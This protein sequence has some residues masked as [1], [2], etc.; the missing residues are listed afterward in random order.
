[1]LFEFP[2]HK[3]IILFLIISVKL[4]HSRLLD[5]ILKLIIFSLLILPRNVPLQCTLIFFLD[6]GAI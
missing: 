2:H 3:Y 5:V 1:V 4:K 6:F